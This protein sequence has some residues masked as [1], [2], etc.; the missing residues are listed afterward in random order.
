MVSRGAVDAL[1]DFFGEGLQQVR[2]LL[3]RVSNHRGSLP[4]RL[5]LF[6]WLSGFVFMSPRMVLRPSWILYWANAGIR[7]RFLRLSWATLEPYQVIVGISRARYLEVSRGPVCDLRRVC[8][9]CLCPA[10]QDDST[11]TEHW[12]LIVS[13][14][15]SCCL[16]AELAGRRLPYS[17]VSLG[18]PQRMHGCEFG[19]VL[20]LLVRAIGCS[21]VQLMTKVFPA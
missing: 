21:A 3:P 12:T 14:D 16:P 11:R 4:N 15:Q 10:G 6:D 2:R 20:I 17:Q 9:G 5:R 19:V 1:G 7:G 8:S 13:D 18:V